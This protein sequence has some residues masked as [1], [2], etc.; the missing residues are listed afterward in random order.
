[1]AHASQV[2]GAETFMG[3]PAGAFHRLLGTEWYRKARL[4]ESAMTI[5]GFSDAQ[6][7]AS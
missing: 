4:A 3:I 6:C 7:A 5:G 1:M 2:L